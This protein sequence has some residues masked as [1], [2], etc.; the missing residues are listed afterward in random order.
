MIVRH[1]LILLSLA[2]L[3]ALNPAFA[4][5]ELSP[6]EEAR[7]KAYEKMLPNKAQ[8]IGPTIDQREPWENLAKHPDD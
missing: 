6:P 7:I 2:N 5:E 4:A 1:S 3:L 8:G